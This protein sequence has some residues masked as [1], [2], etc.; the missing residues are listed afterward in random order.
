MV[1]DFRKKRIKTLNLLHKHPYSYTDRGC[2]ISKKAA[3]RMK[4]TSQDP[5]LKLKKGALSSDVWNSNL[6]RKLL[7]TNK[8]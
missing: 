6:G 2:Y 5:Y 1:S 3:K 4:K 8:K 7:N